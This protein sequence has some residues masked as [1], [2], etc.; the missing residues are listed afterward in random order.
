[1]S[2]TTLSPEIAGARLGNLTASRMADALAKTKSGWGASRAN[3]MAALAVERLTGVP[4]ESYQN[5]AMTWG[6]E[7]EPN[8]IA[9]YCW[10]FDCEVEPTGYVPHPSI[11]HAGATPDGRIVGG[12][13]LIEAKCPQSATHINTL[14]TREIDGR[15]QKQMLWQMA[16][17]GAE[18]VDFITFDPR[19]PHALRLWAFRFERDDKAIAEMEKE[20]RQFLAELEEMVEKLRQIG[21]V[22]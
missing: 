15:Y 9:A 14:L 13:R 21:R 1:M 18:A 17:T 16:C 4:M 22:A 8:A 3:L 2:A 6:V 20:G 19:M 11:P 12:T 5:A 10:E 7:Q